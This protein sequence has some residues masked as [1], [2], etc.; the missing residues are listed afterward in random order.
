MK[1]FILSLLLLSSYV[2]I[3]AKDIKGRIFDSENR[4]IEFVNVA[5]FV[6]GSIVGGCVTDSIGYFTLSVPNNCNKIRER[7]GRE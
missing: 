5:A 2:H 7:Y 1:T 6:N 3:M 4:P